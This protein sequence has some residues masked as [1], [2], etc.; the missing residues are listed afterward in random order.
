M[1][2]TSPTTTHHHIASTQ[3]GRVIEDNGR[4]FVVRPIDSVGQMDKNTSIECVR[5]GRKQ[6]VLV[7]DLVHVQLIDETQGRIERVLH[8]R[9]YLARQDLFKTKEIAA[10][11]DQVI[12]VLS[13]APLF[14][15]Q[16]VSRAIAVCRHQ[17]IDVILLLN[18]IDLT[19]D[20]AKARE[21]IKL[22]DGVKGLRLEVSATHPEFDLELILRPVLAGKTSVMIGPSGAGKTSLLNRLIPDL[23]AA[24][25]EHSTVL[26]QGKHTTTY[27]RA[28]FL[29]NETNSETILVDSPGFHEFGLKQIAIEELMGCFD[30]FKPYLGQCKFRNC[31][32]QGEK[33]CAVALYTQDFNVRYQHYLECL[34]ELEFFYKNR[35]K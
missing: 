30:E 19:T 33:G 8:R 34:A 3:L 21:Q 18:K 1:N 11:I 12:L 35:F 9:N 27:T 4:L 10:N 28:Y 17:Q 24:T 5:K 16:W 29:T 25:R 23:N 6:D 22:F 31:L 2:K 32:H 20:L 7:N 26:N 15:P 13:V 14:N